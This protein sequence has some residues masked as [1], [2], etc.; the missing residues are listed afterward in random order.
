MLATG[1]APRTLPG[2]DID[3]SIVM[4]S[5]E[6]LSLDRIPESAAIIGGGAI[7]CEFASMLIDLGSEVTLLEYLPRLIAGAD[8]DCS[9]VIERSFKKRGHG[10]QDRRRG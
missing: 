8:I 3:G 9:K 6:F 4:T 7:G 10:H 5:D 1:S 2:F